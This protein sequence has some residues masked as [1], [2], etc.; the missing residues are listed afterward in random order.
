MVKL[1]VFLLSL[2]VISLGFY[3]LSE[4]SG[5]LHF[6]LLGYQIETTVTYAALALICG[7]LLLQCFFLV[8]YRIA[9]LPKVFT[10]KRKNTLIELLSEL[11]IAVKIDDQENI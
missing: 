10:N 2:I 6:S 7:I 4:N 9:D 5:S 3:W 1:I 11:I 8:V